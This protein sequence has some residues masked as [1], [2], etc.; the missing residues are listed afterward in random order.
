MPLS[1]DEEHMLELIETGL[2]HQDPEFAAMLT[3]DGVER[4]RRRRIALAHGCLWLGMFLALIGFAV[5]HE[6]LAAGVLLVLYGLTILVFAIVRIL[7]LRP[8]GS[9]YLRYL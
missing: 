1:R 4:T 2:Q 8:P 3:V 7:Q 5:V 6:V 9:G